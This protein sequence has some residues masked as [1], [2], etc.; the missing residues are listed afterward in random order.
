VLF[1]EYHA[2]KLFV[3]VQLGYKFLKTVNMIITYW[4]ITPYI[5]AGKCNVPDNPLS[6]AP[7]VERS[8]ESFSKLSYLYQST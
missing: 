8:S 6:L 3:L 1:S 4:D 5:V 7:G 2:E